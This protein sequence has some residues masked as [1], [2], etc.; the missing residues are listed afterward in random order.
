[1]QGKLDRLIHTLKD[2]MDRL[3]QDNINSKYPF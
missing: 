3:Y 2:Q 1:M